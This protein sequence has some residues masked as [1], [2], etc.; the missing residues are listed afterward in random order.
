MENQI[1]NYA[2]FFKLSYDYLLD[3][4]KNHGVD[5]NNL[6][7]YF[8]PNSSKNTIK[9]L[10][11]QKSLKRIFCR[12]CF[13]AQNGTMVS[14]VINYNKNFE[15]LKKITY[16]FDPNKVLSKY[17]NSDD[18]FKKLCASIRHNPS[19]TEKMEIYSRT[20][21]SG[22]EFVASF[23]SYQDFINKLSSYDE[24]APV[25]VMYNVIGMKTLAYD[26]LKELDDGFDVCK[27][28]VH[29]TECMKI[30]MNVPDYSDSNTL[31]YH[32]SKACKCLANNISA[33]INKKITTYTLDKML[34]L[35]C[36]ET[37]YSDDNIPNRGDKT[38]KRDRY[39]KYIMDN[40]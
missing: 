23:Q 26:F 31:N 24:F 33:A 27:P 38:A 13:H 22:A 3:K 2:H 12:L 9:G 29:L 16:G 1:M 18:I 8:I 5:K 17:N 36:S 39:L 35:I 21:Y 10:P 37:F 7:K 30:L 40:I 32:V 11:K 4:A 25:F 6:N 15:T 28:D 34:F 20:I 19:H 14:G